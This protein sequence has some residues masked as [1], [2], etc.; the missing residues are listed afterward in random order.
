MDTSP[1][2]FFNGCGKPCQPNSWKCVFHRNRGRCLHHGCHNQ[3]YARKLCAKHGGKKQCAVDGC[4]MS[5]R[6]ANVCYKH[7][8]GSLKKRCTFEDCLKPAQLRQRCVRH[9]GGRRCKVAGCETHA[10][11]GGYCCRHGRLFLYES[12]P[13]A[14]F[15]D[16]W[17]MFETTSEE[18][19]S[20]KS[21]SPSQA[22]VESICVV[23]SDATEEGI[24][25]HEPLSFWH[26]DCLDFNSEEL[27]RSK[28]VVDKEVWELLLSM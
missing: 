27:H 25:F 21:G 26:L 19:E 11:S 18:C 1:T 16:V 22:V 7:G 4:E 20:L 2:C 15:E 6:L 3:V 14:D 10:R 9:G 13:A 5:A 24:V 23:E 8:A 17:G 12:D 28:P